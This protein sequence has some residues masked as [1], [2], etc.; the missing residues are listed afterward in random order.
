MHHFLRPDSFWSSLSGYQAMGLDADYFRS[1]FSSSVVLKSSD[2]TDNLLS[3]VPIV[4]KSEEIIGKY[5]IQ[6]NILILVLD[7]ILPSYGATALE[8]YN[9]EDIEHPLLLTRIDSNSINSQFLYLQNQHRSDSFEIP[10][11]TEDLKIYK[12]YE[13]KLIEL[14][15]TYE[16]DLKLDKEYM[17]PPYYQSSVDLLIDQQKVFLM[18][19]YVWFAPKIQDILVIDLEK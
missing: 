10:L 19:R 7:P 4:T 15:A 5:S 17:L 14:S 8:V 11:I 6:K 13:R 16:G 18:P 9:I 12:I 3:P 2:K 1:A